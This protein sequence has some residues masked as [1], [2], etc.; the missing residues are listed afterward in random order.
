MSALLIEDVTLITMD[1]DGRI[2]PKGAVVADS[3][4]ITY[5]GPAAELPEDL[6]RD[7]TRIAGRGRIALP[8]FI[9]AHTHAAMTLFRGYAD[10]LPLQEWL[11]TKIFPIEA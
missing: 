2:I 1:G 11:E 9:N 4:E 10:D 6:P 5:V 8:G 3:G 7:L